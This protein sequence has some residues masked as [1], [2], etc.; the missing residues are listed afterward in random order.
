M[1]SAGAVILWQNGR[2][3]I[4]LAISQP[5]AGR[6]ERFA[7]YGDSGALVYAETDPYKGHFKAIGLL[8]GYCRR[9]D[10][11]VYTPM[12]VVMETLAKGMGKRFKVFSGPARQ[13]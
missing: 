9:K 2:K 8:N 4:E 12:W 11:W 13:G 10:I 3:T 6:C 5:Q 1:T 7:D